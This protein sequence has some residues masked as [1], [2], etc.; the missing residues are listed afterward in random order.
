M[1]ASIKATQVKGRVVGKVPRAAVQLEALVRRRAVELQVTLQT[2]AQRADMTRSHLYKL[3]DG[4]ISDPSVRTLDKIAAA[5]RVSPMALLRFYIRGEQRARKSDTSLVH[6]LHDKSDVVAFTADVTVPDHA[7]LLPAERFV[8]TWAIQ[9]M[10]KVTWRGR[11]FTRVDDDLVVA[12]QR[13]DGVLE[14]I[15][16]A[17]LAS[18]GRTVPVPDT[19]PGMP[20][21][22][23]VD[24]LAPEENCSVAS[25]WRMVDADGEQCFPPEFFLQV[26]VTVIGR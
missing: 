7:L 19:R 6:G 25:I 12:R 22:I 20:C 11:K 17:H 18:L 23:S 14:K 26:I 10:G 3:F 4:T 2:V 13:K 5:I 24:F 15:V 21:E 9:N 1:K 16:D 8:K